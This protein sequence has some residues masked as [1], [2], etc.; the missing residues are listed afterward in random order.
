ME[1]SEALGMVGIGRAVVV[2]VEEGVKGVGDGMVWI[3]SFVFGG[4][5]WIVISS[6]G[7]GRVGELCPF[8]DN[9]GKEGIVISFI[10]TDA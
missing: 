10:T 4:R 7:R 1:R 8:C 2:V 9:G 3:G 6:R 5:G